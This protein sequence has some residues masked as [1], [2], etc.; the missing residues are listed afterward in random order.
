MM[1]R[2]IERYYRIRLTDLGFE[3]TVAANGMDA[4]EE[5]KKKNY[6]VILLD[7]KMPGIDGIELLERIRKE[8][9][10]SSIVIITAYTYED[11]AREAICKGCKKG[12]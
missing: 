11:I 2:G 8:Q 7:M 10:F 9:L 3:T 1:K 5:M 6:A 12:N 4:L